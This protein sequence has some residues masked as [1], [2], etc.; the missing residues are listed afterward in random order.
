MFLHIT[1]D[2]N[3]SKNLQLC[4]QEDI[5]RRL[6]E[7]QQH[8]KNDGRIFYSPFCSKDCYAVRYVVN[9]E[10]VSRGNDSSKQFN[11]T[12]AVT[13]L[14]DRLPIDYFANTKKYG[15]RNSELPPI[16]GIAFSYNTLTHK[17]MDE[18]FVVLHA[19]DEEGKVKEPHS[20]SITLTQGNRNSIRIR[21]ITHKMDVFESSSN[22][23]GH[24]KLN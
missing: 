24:L 22:H 11:L 4:E 19:R 21:S 20:M 10:E 8:S 2:D 23:P 17:E 6:R 12:V 18:P 16:A 3:A 1:W 7:A 14:P 9:I 15:E 5:E 13:A